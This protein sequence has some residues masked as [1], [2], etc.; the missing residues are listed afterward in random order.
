[1]DR[2]E[3]RSTEL[4]QT[5]LRSLALNTLKF[6]QVSTFVLSER[7]LLKFKSAQIFI[8]GELNTGDGFGFY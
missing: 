6:S 1:M 3:N 4:L 8:F 2:V 7:R 5:L